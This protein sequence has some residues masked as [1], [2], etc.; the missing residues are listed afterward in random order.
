MYGGGKESTT[1]YGANAYKDLRHQP[2]KV[3]EE[4]VVWENLPPFPLISAWIFHW[5]ACT[6]WSWIPRFI[7]LEVSN[8]CPYL[9]IIVMVLAILPKK[10]T[11]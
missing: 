2:K 7:S 10:S 9:I 6:L 3:E 8:I 11:N 5:V 1:P 4:A